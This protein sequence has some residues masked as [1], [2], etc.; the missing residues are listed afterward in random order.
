[1]ETSLIRVGVSNLGAARAPELRDSIAL[2]GI[3]GVRSIHT[4]LPRVG[5]GRVEAVRQEGLE[6]RRDSGS[7]GI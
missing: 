4:F 7:E 3:G 2:L 5:A 6:V 1:M